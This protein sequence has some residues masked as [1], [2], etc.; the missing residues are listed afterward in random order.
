MAFSASDRSPASRLQDDRIDAEQTIPVARLPS[1]PHVGLPTSLPSEEKV[2]TEAWPSDPNPKGNDDMEEI[3]EDV[4]MVSTK[5][6]Q[7]TRLPK[8]FQY[9]ESRRLYSKSDE[10]C[11]SEAIHEYRGKGRPTFRVSKNNKIE[12]RKKAMIVTYDGNHLQTWGSFEQTSETEVF[13]QAS[14]TCDT[15]Y[16]SVN[17]RLKE[18][19]VH[20]GC[21]TI[22]PKNLN[23]D[24]G[25][26]S[27]G[28]VMLAGA[29]NA[30][31]IKSQLA[32]FPPATQAKLSDMA[33]NSRLWSTFLD[34]TTESRTWLGRSQ[35]ELDLISAQFAADAGV[36][37][38]TE[39][40]IAALNI[41]K[42]VAIHVPIQA[43]AEAGRA[44][45]DFTAFF[46]SAM[47]MSGMTKHSLKRLATAPPDVG[48]SAAQ[49]ALDGKR[50]RQDTS[51]TPA[52]ENPMNKDHSF[53]IARETVSKIR[54]A[55]GL[56]KNERALFRYIELLEDEKVALHKAVSQSNAALQNAQKKL[57]AEYR[58]TK[59][60]MED[61]IL[62]AKFALRNLE[63][64]ALFLQANNS[65][66]ILSRATVTAEDSLTEAGYLEAA[67]NFASLRQN[68]EPKNEWPE[69]HA[70][71]PDGLLA[72]LE[73]FTKEQLREAESAE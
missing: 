62:A 4:E 20:K 13:I 47:W 36:L 44:F 17:L 45:N 67:S 52:Q 26:E 61:A 38:Q 19:K 41:C 18:N 34:L 11:S 27:L 30:A 12:D 37:S 55:S 50:L 49:R 10:A 43:S 71:H 51:T 14:Y 15:Q 32:G 6:R 70:T 48:R 33:D 54:T 24:L 5:V 9:Q 66:S 60:G 25:N 35:D 63:D 39:R 56:T 1:A 57:Q 68:H 8:D 21:L 16:P 69:L 2:M 31:Q 42:G 29:Q 72:G 23:C 64:T 53:R 22:F 28:L 40:C 59:T 46:K 73:E 7:L 65:E 3:E 58:A